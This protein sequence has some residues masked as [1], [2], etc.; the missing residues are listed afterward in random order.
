MPV[1][2]LYYIPCYKS[3]TSGVLKRGSLPKMATETTILVHGA[4]INLFDRNQPYPKFTKKVS[5]VLQESHEAHHVFFNPVGLH[6][7]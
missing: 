6:V 3:D 7:R 5:E 4:E 1:F 2:H